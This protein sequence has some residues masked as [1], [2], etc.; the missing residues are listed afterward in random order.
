MLL[1]QNRA[2]RLKVFSREANDFGLPQLDAKKWEE[3]LFARPPDDDELMAIQEDLNATPVAVEN[4][5][6][7]SLTTGNVSLNVFIPRSELYYERL[8]G[9]YE[10]GQTFEAFVSAGLT[11]HIQSLIAW[12][13]LR[14]YQLA[15]MLAAQPSISAV[16]GAEAI[17][18]QQRATVFEELATQGDA[19]SRAA[20]IEMGFDHV[21]STAELKEPFTRLIQAAVVAAPIAK[22]DPYKLL[23]SLITLTYG[24]IAYTRVLAAK[25]PYWRRLAAIAQAAMIARCVATTGEDASEFIKWASTVRSSSSCSNALSM[26]GRNQDGSPNSSYRANSGTSLED[27]YGLLRIRAVHLLLKRAGMSSCWMK[28]QE[29]CAIN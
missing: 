27:E 9:K 26:F 21:R 3:V 22:I 23:S 11:R 4:C 1:S 10:P 8:V 20:A 17:A 24:E 16:I 15:L 5:V 25:P 6:R 2:L 18:A 13:P 29:V 14:G 7:G 19:L 12:D 28:R